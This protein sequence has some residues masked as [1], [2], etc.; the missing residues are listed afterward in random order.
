MIVKLLSFIFVISLAFSFP[1]STQA[2]DVPFNVNEVINQVSN[3]NS[4]NA[5]P[6][7]LTPEPTDYDKFLVDTSSVYVG[8]PGAQSYPDIAFDGTNYFVVWAEE[9]NN[10]SADIFGSRVT[11]DGVILDPAGIPISTVTGAQGY[12]AIS[13]DGTNYLV[14]WLDFRNN[15]MYCDIYGSRISQSGTVLDTDGIPISTETRSQEFPSVA[16]DGV[17]YLVVWDDGRSD[18]SWDIYGA[19]VSQAG[20]VL[21]PTGLPIYHKEGN[22][23]YP[24]VAFN[25]TNYLVAWR[26]GQIWGVRVSPNGTVI[27][28][29]VIQ[30]S[31]ASEPNENGPSIASDGINF[32]AVWTNRQIYGARVTPGGIVLDTNNITISQGSNSSD[33]VVDFDGTNY[34]VVWGMGDFRGARVTPAGIVLDP[35]GNIISNAGGSSPSLSF[36]STNYLVVWRDTR[37]NPSDIYGARV[38]PS[39]N[40]LDTTGIPIST[41]ANSQYYPSVASDSTNYLAVW[42]DNRNGKYGIYG[43]RIDQNGALLDSTIIPISIDSVNLYRPSVTFGGSNYFV[44][45]QTRDF[46]QVS[47][48]SD[49]YGARISTEG[50]VLDSNGIPIS[51]DYSWQINPSVASDDTNY[52][53]VW[54][55]HRN[56]NP[57]IYGARITPSGT[58]L[59][60]HGIPI[61]TVSIEDCPAIAF[62]GTNYFVVWQDQSNIYG[63]RVRPTG[64]VL[65]P[66]GIAISLVTDRQCAPAITFGG[67]NYL[68]VWQ[69]N[70]NGNFDIYGT[71][72]TPAGVVLNPS[73]NPISTAPFNQTDPAIVFDGTNYLVVFSDER[74][75]TYNDLYGVLVDTSG[76]VI[77][78][79]AVDTRLGHQNNPA[80]VRSNSNQI[81][82][83]YSGWTDYINSHTANTMRIWG[84]FYPFTGGIEEENSKVKIQ[85]TK[86]LEVYPNP[87]RSVVRVRYSWA[88]EEKTDLKIFD[89]SGKMVKEI[90]TPASQAR[91]DQ[92]SDIKIS[93]KGTN[94][95]IYF[96]KVGKETKKFLVVK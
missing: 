13:F 48:T 36:D 28:T 79:F 38:T 35:N 96:L 26:E 68:I 75:Q 19:R 73:G 15:D 90:A 62:D 4:L 10:V 40:V 39:N 55:D 85:S 29:S 66:T 6:Y 70:R 22:Q 37:N 93:L 67:T 60:P 65:D 54:S 72:V 82:I 71:R 47:G 59:D 92:A 83:T 18:S 58:I 7:P 17:N 87:A 69:D 88:T 41:A 78:S 31:R 8:A 44:V 3:Y 89:V 51:L 95:G 45:W 33:P 21:D 11:T 63:A 86:L 94:P 2:K 81:L 74:S 80:L 30:I 53:A 14:V 12:P 9:R 76:V 52:F 25:G 43:E 23:R 32:L 27:D 61:S 46:N 84:M 50:T 49:I 64:T 1:V 16:F 91:N 77:D 42:Q 5:H 20:I 57:D 34:F 56:G 24:F